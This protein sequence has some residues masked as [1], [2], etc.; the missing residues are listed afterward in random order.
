MRLTA[1]QH[2]LLAYAIGLGII[3]L[4]AVKTWLGLRREA[5]RT[6]RRNQA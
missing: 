3:W 6:A 1:E 4:Y 2:I 5:A